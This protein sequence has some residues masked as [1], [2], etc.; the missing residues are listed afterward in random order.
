MNPALRN[1]LLAA[2]AGGAIAIAGI[3]VKWYEGTRYEPYQ[4][5]AGIWTVCEGVT[6]PDVVQGKTYTEAECTTLRTKHLRQA[7]ARARAA[8]PNWDSLDKWIQAALIDFTYNLGG[9]ALQDTEIGRRFRAGDIVGGCQQLSRW[10]KARVHGQLV[11]LNGL[12][13]RRGAE[14]EICLEGATHARIP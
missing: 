10:V 14:Q 1:R 7:E 3:L 6:G 9:A 4:D 11:T 8:L 2:S 12:V 5:P 13:D